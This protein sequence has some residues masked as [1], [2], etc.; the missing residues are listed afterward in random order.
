MEVALFAINYGSVL[1]AFAFYKRGL[2]M[3]QIW[4]IDYRKRLDIDDLPLWLKYFPRPLGQWLWH[5]GQNGRFRHTKN[6]VRIRSNRFALGNLNLGA[7]VTTTL[8]HQPN[9]G[10]LQ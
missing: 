2:P 7:F 4:P 8:Y 5:S 3:L 9:C 1:R 10:I 6:E